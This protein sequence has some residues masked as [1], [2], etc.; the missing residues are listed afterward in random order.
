MIARWWCGVV[1]VGTICAGVVAPARAAVI[2]EKKSG[3]LIIRTACR[4]KETQLNLADFGAV[5]PKGDIGPKGD[6]GDPGAVGP[7]NALS[8]FKNGPV[9]VPSGLASIAALSI[10]T[11]GT[12]VMVA[13]VELF[14]NVNTGVDVQ[15]QLVAGS[16]VDAAS[17]V[18][19]GN[20]GIVVNDATVAFNVVHEFT[21][22]G[23]VQLQCNAFGV[24]VDAF[25]IKITAIQVG[26]LTNTSLP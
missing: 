20:S 7:S 19:E 16:D 12:Y 22:A 2:C 3:A 10:P 5:G 11:P 24:N 8:G 26:S 4:K 14:D 15:C 21:S 17:T 9:A 1:L 13:K 23:S 25:N 18:L 6:K